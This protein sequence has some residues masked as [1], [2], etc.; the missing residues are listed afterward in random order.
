MALSPVCRRIRV[1]SWNRCY[2]IQLIGWKA[3]GRREQ[4]DK[5]PEIDA[6]KRGPVYRLAISALIL[7]SISGGSV[8]FL[9]V[10]SCTPSTPVI[11]TVVAVSQPATSSVIFHRKYSTVNFSSSERKWRQPTTTDVAF[12]F[13]T[14]AITRANTWRRCI[15]NPFEAFCMRVY[16]H[17]IGSYVYTAFIPPDATATW[18][19]EAASF[20]SRPKRTFHDHGSYVIA[21]R[22]MNAR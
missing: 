15:H 5:W 4:I 17:G 12:T 18:K 2:R 14:N 13:S 19:T 16:T 9:V 22:P 20:F 21:F 10:P 3:T 11:S 8:P 6:I 7:V 1:K